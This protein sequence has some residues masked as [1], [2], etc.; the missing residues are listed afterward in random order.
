MSAAQ[1]K[2][3]NSDGFGLGNN[4]SNKKKNDTSQGTAK[5]ATITVAVIAVLF[6]LALFINSNYFRQNFSVVKI[7]NVKYAITDFNYYYNNMYAQYYNAISGQGEFSSML[8]S[9]DSLK[10][11]IY[12]EETGETWADF[13]ENVAIDQMEADTK[14]YNEAMNAGY[15]LTEEDKTNL[16]SDLSNMELSGISNGYPTFND[17]LKVYYGKSMT[18]AEYRENLERSYLISSYTNYIRDSFSYTPD[19]I[20]T[21][22]SENK[23]T[24]DTF[25][26]RYFLVSADEV[27]ESEYEDDAAYE[28][29]KAAAVAAAGEKA[30]AI[31][32]DITDEES[33]IAAARAYNPDTYQE[34]DS[35]QRTYK[36]DLLGSTYGDWLREADRQYGDVSTFE[37]TNGHYVVFYD[38]RDDNHY[39]TA[40]VQQILVKPETIDPTLYAEEEDTTAYD[41]AVADAKKTAE[42]T[43]EKIY[44]EWLDGGATEEK[45]TQLTTD[46]AAEISVG[47]SVLNENV[48]KGQLPNEVNTWIFDDARKPGDHT[49]VYDETMGYYIL[50]YVG[51]GEQYSTLLADTKQRDQDLQAWKDGLTGGEPTTTWLMTLTK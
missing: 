4:S 28:E 18:E 31:A 34:D 22:Y 15:Q 29:A 33:F 3:K 6:L 7:D 17:F 50:N 40:N 30:R 19:E 27:N 39:L 48:F 25:T 45:M 47:D 24:F 10:S 32:A 26:Y 20:E 2:R 14:I 36:G 11:E 12:N 37:S 35:T 51:A 38:S 1:N 5:V 13:F 41:K 43:A 46:Y 21:Y 8:P 42:E 23:D 9:K 49:L 16:E 44:Q